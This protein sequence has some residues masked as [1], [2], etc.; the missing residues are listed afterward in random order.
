MNNELNNLGILISGNGTT[1]EAVIRSCRDDILQGKI[2]SAIVISSK[3]N[4]G[5]IEKVKLLDVP[6][7]VIRKKDF[8]TDKD[9]GSK[10]L[11][12]LGGYKVNLVV[13]MGW[14][15]KTPE[16][17]VREFEGRIFNQHPGSL[18][19]DHLGND[20]NPL[21]FGGQGMYGIH[22]HE[23]VL[24]FQELAQRRFPTEATIHRVTAKY[25]QGRVV[26]KREVL[27]L[28]N[29][30]AEILSQRVLPVEH[31]LMIDF[32]DQL[33]KGQVHELRRE[34]PLIKIG[35]EGLLIQA[36]QFDTAIRRN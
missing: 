15:T 17:V 11:E 5:G 33:S 26:A 27:V 28:D 22:V 36:K 16:E 12:I 32:L 4:A 3:K 13:Q 1:M 9:F 29:D 21:D 10:L 31:A 2:N 7:E 20:G 35:E 23:T 25:D 18:D 19:P 30:T 14:L 8:T 34:V 24:K 6:F